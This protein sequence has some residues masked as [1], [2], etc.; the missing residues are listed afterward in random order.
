MQWALQVFNYMI[1]HVAISKTQKNVG[2]TSIT[3]LKHIGLSD[4]VRQAHCITHYSGQ[5][6][7]Q[8]EN[9]NL[10]FVHFRPNQV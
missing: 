2:M 4:A 9:R 8:C 7:S 5:C 6:I 10:Q 3:C 1:R